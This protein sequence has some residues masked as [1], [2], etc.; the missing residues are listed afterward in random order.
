[1]TQQIGSPD[2]SYIQECPYFRKFLRPWNIFSLMR[3]TSL[4]LTSLLRPSVPRVS[5]SVGR[6]RLSLL[7]QLL[8]FLL[9]QQLMLLSLG[10]LCVLF[11]HGP[12]IFLLSFGL[13]VLCGEGQSGGSGLERE[14]SSV[15]S[16][17][18]HARQEKRHWHFSEYMCTC[19]PFLHFLFP[20]SS[21]FFT[22]RI[23]I[24]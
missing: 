3:Q 14:Q 15:A 1:M 23:V 22:F 8:L 10:S 21:V 13:F 5:C 20:H 12:I 19:F 17:G 6:R 7:L 18:C 2:L 24:I 11:L 9:L 16:L 4:T